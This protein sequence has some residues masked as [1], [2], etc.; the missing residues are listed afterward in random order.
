MY[1]PIISGFVDF[2]VYH[3]DG[4]PIYFVNGKLYAGFDMLASVDCM[5][6]FVFPDTQ[7]EIETAIKKNMYMFDVEESNK[8]FYPNDNMFSKDNSTKN[9][10]GTILTLK[11]KY[12]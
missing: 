4:E 5:Y 1:K 3:S 6:D 9:I 7:K 2:C 11:G 12:R 8:F 10:K